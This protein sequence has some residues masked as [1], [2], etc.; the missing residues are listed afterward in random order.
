MMT[1]KTKLAYLIKIK[2]VTGAEKHVLDLCAGLKD[3]FEIHA[4]ILEKKDFPQNDYCQQ[5][6][7]LGVHVHRVLLQKTFSLKTVLA[8]Y[9]Y[10]KKNQIAI[11]HTHLMAADFIGYCVKRVL[12]NI[13]WVS[14]VHNIHSF[15]SMKKTVLKIY[16]RVMKSVDQLI[17]PTQFLKSRLSDLVPPQKTYVIPHGVALRQKIDPKHTNASEIRIL[18]VGRLIP[19]KGAEDLIKAFS[20]F[21]AGRRDVFLDMVGDGPEKESLE[22]LVS[23]LQLGENVIFHGYQKDVASFYAR[24]QV[25]VLSSHTEGFGL[26]LLEAMSFGLAIVATEITSIPECVSDEKSALLVKPR[27]IF[28]MSLALKKLAGD[29][30]L[31]RSLGEEARRVFQEKFTLEKMIARYRIQYRIC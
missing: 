15:L 31:M 1:R 20:L 22:K 11:L 9:A 25:F 14:T 8:V 19:L 17:F 24:A 5:L 26:S 28:Q 21:S 13:S 7:D 6:Q 16:H 30:V 18:F 3:E 12:K 2:G 23:D 10:L 29:P 4:V 27:D